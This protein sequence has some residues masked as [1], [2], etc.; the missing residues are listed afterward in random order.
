MNFLALGNNRISTVT[1]LQ[2]L[3][4]LPELEILELQDN[5]CC[6]EE[7]YRE[8]V[9][10]ALPS[11]K[12]VD[13]LDRAGRETE[14]EN[15]SEYI[16]NVGNSRLDLLELLEGEGEGEEAEGPREDCARSPSSYAAEP[17]RARKNSLEQAMAANPGLFSVFLPHHRS[18][19]AHHRS[20]TP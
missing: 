8:A 1:A 20:S 11:V 2:Q 15:P 19:T 4:C 17:L 10:A 3:K 9:F 16:S 13:R 7:D 18:S 12:V 6:H 5:E 14:E